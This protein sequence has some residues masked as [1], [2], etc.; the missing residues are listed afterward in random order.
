MVFIFVL[1]GAI[2]L[3]CSLS[4]LFFKIP[5]AVIIVVTGGMLVFWFFA[6]AKLFRGKSE[7]DDEMSRKNQ[8]LARTFSWVAAVLEISGLELYAIFSGKPVLL[9]ADILSLL[10]ASM[11]LIYGILF[12]VLDKWGK[13]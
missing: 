3:L 11:F 5:D 8:D 2:L 4:D 9:T 6:L 10:L 12:L 13:A 1:P 7:R